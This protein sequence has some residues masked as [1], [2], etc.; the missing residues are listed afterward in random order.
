[1]VGKPLLTILTPT[2]NRRNLLG[3]LYESIA[4]QDVSVDLFEWLVVDDGSTDGTDQYIREL[5]SRSAF[6][7]KYLY[8]QNGGKCRAINSAVSSLESDWVIIVD[9]D[10]WFLDGGINN[11]LKLIA[12]A[13]STGDCKA[14][15][16]PHDFLNRKQVSPFRNAY[17]ISFKEWMQSHEFYDACHIICV[18]ILKAFPFPEF[19]DEK[20]IAE[21]S[22]YATA[23]QHGGICLIDE[24]L[25][26]AE[27]QD[28]GLSARSAYLRMASPQGSAYTYA[29]FLE[30]GLTGVWRLRALVNYYRFF[31][32]ANL[33][34]CKQVKTIKTRNYILMAIG[35][36]TFLSDRLRL[37]IDRFQGGSG[38]ST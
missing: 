4:S 14:I 6:Q 8:R 16:T 15:L 24:R 26:R 5:A 20:S 23:F 9:S 30:A 13:E 7:I 12:Q 2:Y 37:V 27:Y 33:I 34:K 28:T 32:H 19:P 18:S 10:D 21:G 29:S 3:R 25:T 22:F 38:N 1:M 35:Y 17:G 36:L 31:W 11:A